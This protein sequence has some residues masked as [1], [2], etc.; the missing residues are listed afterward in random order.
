M[1]T[2]RTR[3]RILV[4]VV[5][6]AAAITASLNFVSSPASGQGRRHKIYARDGKVAAGIVSQGGRLIADYGSFQVLEA[7]ESTA[8]AA[9]GSGLAEV[10]DEQNLILLNSGS[11]DTSRDDVQALRNAPVGDRRLHL[12]QFAGPIKPEWHAS[13]AA[14]GVEIVNYIPHNAYLVYGGEESL[15]DLQAWGNLAPHMQWEGAYDARLK[16]SPSASSPKA[17]GPSPDDDLFGIQLFADEAVNQETLALIGSLRLAEIR[18]Q[19]RVAKFINIIAPLPQSAVA[20]VAARPDVISIT[21]YAVPRRFDERQCQIVA[22]NLSGSQPAPG[23]Y[24]SYLAAQGFTQSQFTT[25]G[26]AVNISDSGVDNATTS[27]NHFGLRTEGSLANPGRLVYARLVG[28]PSGAGSTIQGCDGHGTINAHILAGYVPSGVPFTGFPHAEAGGFRYGMGIAPFVKVGSSVIFDG[29]GSPFGDYTYPNFNDLESTAYQDGSRISSNSW[30]ATAGGEYTFDSQAYDYL[31]RD[32]QPEGAPFETAG[33]QQNVIVFAAGNLGPTSQTVG[34]PGTAKNVITA[35]ASENVHPFGGADK[36]TTADVEA[37]SAHDMSIFSSRG[38]TLDG[39]KKPDIVAPGTHITG[40]VFQIANPPATGQADPCFN[41]TGVCGGPPSSPNFFPP[42]QQYYTASSGTSHSTPAIAGAAALIRQRFINEGLLPPS[43]AMTKAVLMNTARYLTGNDANDTLWSNIQGMGAVNLK[44][45]LGIFS[46]PTLIR[47]QENIDLLTASGQARTIN[48][49]IND[50]SKPFRATLAWTDDPGSTTGSASVN[51]LDLEVTIGGQTYKGNVFNGAFSTAGGTF[52]DKNNVESV[53]IPAGVTGSF[54]VRIIA[55]NIA[56]DGV[57]NNATPLDQDFALAVFN[58]TEAIQPLI[59]TAGSSVT[60][61]S[62]EPANGALD[63]GETAAV[64]LSLQNVGRAPTN[65]LV[66][67]LLSTGGVI[68][69]SAPQ[70]YG[71]LAPLGA[72]ASRQFTFRAGGICGTD[73]TATLQLQD[74]STSLGT[75]TFIFRLGSTTTQTNSFTNAASIAIP[76]SGAASPYPSTIGVSGLSGTISRVTVAVSNISHTYPDDL[77]LLLVAPGGQKIL[78]MSD[79][80]GGA[81]LVNHNLVFD[82]GAP[83]LPNTQAIASGTHSPTNFGIGDSLPQ[84]APAGPYPDPQQLAAF[85]GLNPNGVWSLYVFDDLASNS[86]SIAGGWSLTI[87]TAS[88]VCCGSVPC[89]MVVGPSSIPAGN[90]GTAY[91]QTFTQTGGAQPVTFNLSGALPAGMSFTNG[92]LSG[93]PSQGGSYPITATAIDALGCASSTSYT[94]VINCPSVSVSPATL[95]NGFTGAAYNQSISASPPGGN[96]TFAVTLGNL[97]T[98][99]S[100]NSSTGAISG[101]PAITGT[102]NFTITAT[103]FGSCPASRNYTVTIACPSIAIAPDSLSAGTVNAPYN[104]TIS[105][106]GGAAPYTFSLN[107]GS[108]PGGMSLS[109]SGTLGGTPSASGTSNFSV[110]ATDAYGCMQ[111]KSYSLTINPGGPAGL[112]YYPLPFPVR[113]LDTRPGE[114]ACHAPGLPLAGNAVRTQQATGNCGGATI[115]ASAKAITGNATVVNFISPGANWITLFPSDAAQPNASNLNFSDNQIVPNQFTVGLGTDGAFK[116]YS[117]AAT[118]FIVD[119]TGY[120]APPGAGGLYYHPLPA[121]VRLFDSRSGETA[122]EA[123]GVPLGDDATRTVLAH[124]SC[125]GATIPPTAKAIV[126]NATVVNFISSG[127]NWITLYP[128]G[129]SQPNASNLNFTANQ[130]VPNAFIVGLSN[131]GKFNLYSRGST[132]FILDVN[133]YFSDEAVDVNGQGLLYTPLPTPVRLLDTRPGEAGC[134]A[135]GVALGNNA[136][137]TQSSHRT[138]FGVTIPSAA[139]AVVG[140]ATVVN[141]ISSGFNWITLYPSGAFQPI[142]SNLNFID[143]Q[144][145]PNAFVVGLSSDGKFN[146]YSSAS[147]H[148]IVDLTG[149]FAP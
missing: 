26:F 33:N 29:S 8:L 76:A 42:T 86:G 50:P 147:T 138:C 101:T 28:T 119:V 52:D 67:T 58:M 31:V 124:R 47:D 77:D 128:F 81:D 146:I 103:G 69:P 14:S 48:G 66:A 125:L 143:N 73:L 92:L 34:A 74:G 51:N 88:P 108:L 100:I 71:V 93:T 106:S 97:P 63:P 11:L 107:S 134:D 116:I 64:S 79:C 9:A 13:L 144:V 130:I 10:R 114:Q 91:S 39:R 32:A 123:P 20:Q 18:H 126:G 115:P 21:R 56:G 135:P 65:N 61:E 55:A 46:A 37:D 49:T 83:Q 87:T 62:C 15:K 111:T 131:D 139:K 4:L 95:P 98:G 75:A 27:P 145:V 30:G 25:S 96:Y 84:P 24:L 19:F 118:H 120:Y 99:L 45:A 122:C 23:D 80:G 90:T 40:G 129:A 3:T 53:F 60:S 109:S 57:P 127:S 38:P 54:T 22:G 132:H 2:A 68:D 113:L 133:G 5:I 121:P 85:N 112:Q 140:N 148:F 41:A 149:F 137:R 110:K 12:V 104:Q 59:D 6:F 35:G 72:S 43:P 78:L 89:T 82:D 117:R 36:C 141:F 16:I 17:S 70:S 105:A 142:A 7:G 94:L 136:T 44:T 102:Y 1:Q